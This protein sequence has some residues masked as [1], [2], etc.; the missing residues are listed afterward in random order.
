MYFVFAA[1]LTE[2]ECRLTCELVDF[3]ICPWLLCEDRNDFGKWKPKSWH[4]RACRGDKSPFS[5]ATG[6]RRVSDLRRK[7]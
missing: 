4:R 1:C 5:L 6:L 2:L 3:V 7:T